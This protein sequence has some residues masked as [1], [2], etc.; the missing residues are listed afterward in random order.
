MNYNKITMKQIADEC[1]VSMMTVSRA[2]S[3]KHKD[4]LRPATRDLILRAI[5][6]YNYKFNQSASRLKRNKLDTITLIMG[7]RA[8][9]VPETTP[10]FDLHYEVISWGVVKGVVQEARK[11]NYDVKIEPVIE[12]DSYNT[13]IENITSKM[14]DGVLFWGAYNLNKIIQHVKN[15]KMPN[16]VM[17]KIDSDVHGIGKGYVLIDRKKGLEETVKYLYEKKH[18]KIGFVGCEDQ[19]ASMNHSQLFSNYL[20]TKEIFDSNIF[21]S[22]RTSLDLRK[23]LLSFNNKFP[24]TALMCANDSLADMT[25]KE[26]RF[27]GV[28]VPA[29]VAV[30]GFDGNPVYQRKGQTNIST[31]YMPDVE[32]A[33]VATQMLIENIEKGLYIPGPMKIIPSS[34]IPGATT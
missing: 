32:A 15:I 34:F 30:T 22:V 24:F 12:S 6:K 4:K 8:T 10:D 25:V 14:T 1:G 33:T 23:L 29:D 17:A 21:Y 26:L 31:V 11:H 27:M 7:K 5:K 28:K 19:T 18:R 2:L 13:V 3:L 20:K 9:D 16:I